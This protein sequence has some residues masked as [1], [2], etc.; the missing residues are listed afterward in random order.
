MEEKL[1]VI[2]QELLKVERVGIHD[3]FFELGGDSIITIQVVSRAKRAGIPLQ[4]R[5]LFQ[6]QTLAALAACVRE[7]SGSTAEQGQLE[8]ESPLLPIQHWFFAQSHAEPSHFNQAVLL[9]LDKQVSQQQLSQAM[10]ALVSQH[11]ALRFQYTCEDGSW[12]QSYGAHS[13]E[14]DLVDLKDV[15]VASLPLAIA[16][17]CDQYQRS[18]DIEKGA[19]F[20]MVFIQTPASTSHHRLFLVI[21]HLVVDGVSWR[22]LLQ[23]LQ[24]C[25]DG[26]G[27]QQPIALYAK[28]S[29]YRQWAEALAAY[30]ESVYVES[31]LPYWQS[32]SEANQ[33]LPVD[34]VGE[35][36][37]RN[38]VHQHQV[39]LAATLTSALVSGV[40]QAYAT[41]I[42]DLLLAALGQTIQV[43]TH[44]PQIVIG[45]EGHGREYLSERVEISQ[46]VGWFTNL[47]PVRLTVEEGQSAGNLIKSIKEQL[48]AIPDKGLGYGALRYLHPKEEVRAS[49]SGDQS[50]GIVFNYLGQLDNAVSASQWLSLASES[51]GISVGEGNAFGCQLEINS[52][53]VGGQL[54]ISWNYAATQYES[55]TIAKLAEQYLVNL[56]ALISHCQSQPITQHTPSDYGLGN[57]VSYQELDAFLQASY[58]EGLRR[59]AISALYSL[60]PLQ[61]GMLFHGLYDQSAY[62]EQLSCDLLEVETSFLKA[63]W[64]NVLENHSVLRSGFY[65]QELPM[66]VQCV[67][68]SVSMPFEELDYRRW[69]PEE[70]KSQWTIF[71][72]E[73]RARGFDFGQA[74][75][76]RITLIRLS[77][78]RY[79]ML[80]TSHHILLD[81]WSM[82][83]IMGEWLRNYECLVAGEKFPTR[84]E[85]KYADFI[86]Y[87]KA[88]DSRADD[89]FWQQYLSG[90]SGP[91]FLPFVASTEERNKGGTIYRK[92]TLR[93]DASVTAAIRDFTQRNRLTVNTL[94]QGA[95]ALLL[96]NYTQSKDVVYGVIVSGRPADLAGAEQRVGLYINTIPL[97]ATIDE[98][99]GIVDWLQAL[100]QNQ[101]V[102]RDYQHSSL[103]AIQQGQDLFDTLMIVENYPLGEVLTQDWSLQVENVQMEEQ[104]NYLLSIIVNLGKTIT[105]DFSYNAALLQEP[106]V[107]MIKGHFEHLLPQ[108]T[109][110][111]QA[112]MSEIEVLTEPE[113]YQLLTEFTNTAAAYPIDKTIVD[114]LEAQV[115]RTPTQ[116]AVVFEG[117]ALTYA[118]LNDRSNQLAHYLTNK[119]VQK[120]SLVAI[121]IE[122]SLEMLIG[123]LG[124][125]KAGA[126]YVPIDPAYPQ[127]RID[128]MF[129]DSGAKLILSSKPS[130]ARLPERDEAREVIWLD[131]DW[132][133]IA[134][135]PTSK[136]EITIQP[137]QLV[138][139]IYTSG[140]TGRPKGVMIEHGSL[141]NLVLSQ[142][143]A[144]RLSPQDKTLQFSSLSFD[145]SC[146][147]IFNT[148]AS[149]GCL[150]IPTKEVLLSM[151]LL[152][153]LIAQHQ[154]TVAVL[155]PSYQ[156][157]IQSQIHSVKTLVSAGEALKVDIARPL[158]AKGIRVI[159]AY[160]PTENTVCVT[161]S[162]S[163]LCEDGRVTIGQPLSNVQVYLLDKALQLVP[164]GVAGEL[165]V[166]GRQVARGYL[167]QPI[168][169]QEKFIPDPF[170][171]DSAGRLYKTGDMARWLPDGRIELLGRQDEQVKIRGHRIE[172]GEVETALQQMAGVLQSVVVA[173]ADGNGSQRLVGYVVMAEAFD[174]QV[175]L[176]QL[177]GQLPEYMVPSLLMALDQ[178]P[179]MPNGKVD[180]KALPNPTLAP[181]S[182]TYVAPRTHTEEKLAVIWQQLLKVEGVGIHDNFFELGGHSLLATRVVSA[183]RK[184]LLLEVSIKDIFTHATLEGLAMHLQQQGHVALLPS[185]QLAARPLHIPL[186]Y[187]QERLW[188]IDQLQ[189]SLHYHIPAVLRLQGVLDKEALT[190]A[191]SSIVNRHEVL[192]TVVQQGENGDYQQIKQKDAWSLAYVNRAAD[193][194]DESNQRLA[195]FIEESVQQPFDLSKDDM[196]R[197]QLV[198]LAMEEHVLIIT[199]H[200][201]AADGWSVSIL[202]QELVEFY[203]SKQAGR[204]AILP[205]LPVQ[206]ADYSI[207]QRAYLQEKGEDSLRYWKKQLTGVTPLTLLTDYA[208]PA[209]QTTR[210]GV[211]EFS[212]DQQ[213][214]EQVKQL[215]QA[216][217]V[218]LFM[219]LLTVF[220]VLLYRYSGQEDICVGTP[221]AGRDRREVEPLIGFFINMLALRSNLAH[222]PSFSTL[223]QQ[224][225]G[226]TLEAYAHQQVPFEKVVER[227]VTERDTS[228]SPLFQ[229]MFVLQNAPEVPQLRLGEVSLQSVPFESHTT[230]FD[231]TFAIEEGALGLQLMVEYNKDL[232]TSATIEK[233]VAH[234]KHLLASV[235]KDVHQ[236][237]AT[238]PMLNTAEEQQLRVD[239]N[240]TSVAG[241]PNTTLVDL[242]EAQAGRTPDQMAVVFQGRQLTYQQ[243]HEQSNQLAH[244]LRA[245][246]IREDS[247]IPLCVPRSLEML[248]G[249]LGIIK[250]GAAYVP[251]DLNY[252]QERIDYMLRDTNAQLIISTQQGRS[253]LA[254]QPATEVILLDSDWPIIA[255]YPTVAPP[256][257]LT[258][259]HLAYVIYTS[260][261]TG[262]PKGVMV[263]HQGVVNMVLDQ[264]AALRLRSQ[265]RLLQCAS[266]SFDASC[267]ELFN[268]WV[269]GGAIVLPSQEEL[270]NPDALGA[271]I[272]EHSVTVVA[273][274]PSFQRLLGEHLFQL[275]AVISGGEALDVELVRQLQSKGIRTINSYGPTET[276]VCVAFS[277]SPLG[278][279]GR[280]TIGQPLKN[281][282]IYLLDKALQLVPIGVAGELYVG[283]RQVARGYLNQ[284]VLTQEKFIA[285]PFSQQAEARLYKTGDMAR[286]LP[287]GSI[288]LLGR[289][290]EQVKIR[291]HRIELG[292][293]EAA[294]QQMVGVLQSVVVAQAD[295]HGSQRLVGY[296][297]MAE[298]FDS[299]A[300]LSQLRRKLPE[301][302]VPSLLVSLEQLPLTPN[303]KV[304]KKALPNPTL[305]LRSQAYIA[306]RTL[307]EEKL[308]LVWQQL[309][310]VERVGIHDNFFELGGHSLL[311]VQLQ[312]E[313]AK[314]FS[315]PISIASLFD[316]PT[317]ASFC[318]A[319][320]KG[321]TDDYPIAYEQELLTLADLPPFDKSLS[322]TYMQHVLLTGCTG[323]LGAFILRELLENTE[324]MIYCL[325]R[326]SN[327][328][329][330]G[331][332]INSALAK[333]GLWKDAYASRVKAVKGDLSEPKLGIPEDS[334]QQLTQQ[335]D[336]V[337]HN[338]TYMNHLST[339]KDAKKINVD[340][341]KEVLKFA[342]DKR[343][344]RVH[345]VSTMGVFGHSPVKRTVDEQS[346]IT[347][348]IHYNSSGYN[349]SKWV[350]ENV[351]RES[352]ALGIPVT[353]YRPGL[354]TYSS[355]TKLIDQ[356]QWLSLM[357]ETCKLTNKYPVSHG[358]INAMSVD[359]AA[360]HL[361]FSIIDKNNANRTF[362]LWN[363][364][365][366]GLEDILS[367]YFG[368]ALAQMEQV[369][370][371]AFVDEIRGTDLP[372]SPM[373]LLL[374]EG[375]K[376]EETSEVT[377][378]SSKESESYFQTQYSSRLS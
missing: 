302:M 314:L 157:I 117:Q 319:I 17:V 253:Q 170:S 258:A 93:L 349:A 224:I 61:E 305:A 240:P 172:L 312:K 329:Q 140:S 303:G 151:E 325:V 339:Y 165:Y 24:T 332:R 175:I 37:M 209:L 38:E 377:I 199:A 18:L 367:A 54:E 338:G 145:A 269:S 268:I 297:V 318:Q 309:L 346:S 212:I 88:R 351:M 214:S 223:L 313:L 371:S 22:I 25:L 334:Y 164:V 245:K 60:S 1:A 229:V 153:E 39:K 237:I 14:I 96:A 123:L 356:D 322:P 55:A 306:P 273:A 374:D 189:G 48:R 148:L 7:E 222:N 235:V 308:A 50:W 203:Q 74:P 264:S 236:P 265:D 139:V 220:K 304:D 362:H 103:A 246:G 219:G 106:E 232:Y 282:P 5:D 270:T 336:C 248:I 285:D 19:L 225:K 215:C 190:Y 194:L 83:V 86:D 179:L 134:Q 23:D 181:R 155:P 292:E 111:S 195:T 107:K 141:V 63:C 143:E 49:L 331:R 293:V 228:R 129:T 46:T 150:V 44:D 78:T 64:D 274:T 341:A 57:Q 102:C 316:H 127:D 281:V 177:R 87:L 279:D 263:A 47:Y 326:C 283:G 205:E 272:A 69:S 300:I 277:D 261:T 62:I 163:P 191:L 242:L 320:S 213:V 239:F 169:T 350:A 114:L 45:L 259:Q 364:A 10:T 353:I 324:A 138:Y 227:V 192:R 104:T 271:L 299:P 241:P 255:S 290:D 159:N 65:Y 376:A 147:E 335:I 4:P 378:F 276:T 217:E 51:T 109:S 142:I 373:L 254:N 247:L 238:L 206:Y 201:I 144:L 75:L 343:L 200:H 344:K 59:D 178:L 321:E 79:K 231:L 284:P 291:G 101:T 42:N 327:L 94:M 294:L 176:S 180:K 98:A 171:Q 40:H 198:E 342:V 35:V 112:K 161:L 286:W 110:Q 167:N 369:S 120:E 166:G 156:P 168:L 372:L 208:R 187:A 315:E 71:L 347:A 348:E 146:Y 122:R 3:N 9:Q 6:H 352:R 174:A 11:D 210:G 137:Q 267:F 20:R 53:I 185:I 21:H 360:K 124:I 158:Q 250:A 76:M 131:E 73:D 221:I 34:K 323:F 68:D 121:C 202:V 257:Q 100:Q 357:I 28:S 370:F 70:Q 234:Y 317:I 359:M 230:K 16:Q 125:I 295:G 128:Y 256:T 115:A 266:L 72:Q 296:V 307:T 29:S 280:V 218:T 36:P 133:T 99:A 366:V 193:R 311:T 310:K 340:G 154:I 149:G 126:A 363:H 330:G 207:W 333:Y 288:E 136:V 204:A 108:L 118:E 188:F 43:W 197:A 354:V 289:Q 85:D 337:I 328:E 95:W 135:Q 81:G 211:L 58:G 27:E 244:Y 182:Q 113:K 275:K 41:G 80:W 249:L 56:G 262:Q 67:Y 119:G 152:G 375:M 233:L 216:Q 84:Q 33:P 278:E 365:S 355:D 82:P 345:Y 32:V 97:R 77:A 92:E 252:P 66:A 301:Y 89:Q 368:S 15:A 12:T 260:G 298:A 132:S 91:T 358:E 116:V 184:E 162:D 130:S 31:Q 160:G 30:A 13:V 196:L 287:D 173:Q 26:L 251:V 8:G 105:I 226:M 361:V 2:W 183:I 186:S 243:L 52:S 90:L